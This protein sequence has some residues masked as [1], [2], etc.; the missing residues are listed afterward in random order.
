MYQQS[1][2]QM[3]ANLLLQFSFASSLVIGILA[4]TLLVLI[5]TQLDRNVEQCG[6]TVLR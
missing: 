4:I 5:T 6:N 2:K 1:M 3:K